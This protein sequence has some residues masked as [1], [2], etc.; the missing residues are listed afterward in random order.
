[1]TRREL[2]LAALTFALAA[3]RQDATAPTVRGTEPDPD[4]GASVS[5]ASNTYAFTTI[6]DSNRDGFDPSTFGC[7]ALNDPGSVA[8]RA[9]RPNG[10]T[11]IYRGRGGPL[12]TIV[13]DG[14][15]IYDFIGR[16]PS[17]NNLGDVSFAA[18]LDAGGEAI[19]RG[20]GGQLTTIAQTQPGPFNFFGFDTS[21]NDQGNVAFKAELDTFDEGLF[22]GSGGAVTTVYLASTSQFSGT[23]T[24]PA[25]NNAG[26]I[27]FEERLDN[28][29]QGMFRW[30][31]G[32]FTTIATDAAALI[33][34]F[35]GVPA[36]SENGLVA[37]HA[38]D[39]LGSDE[40]IGRGS[41]GRPV[42]VVTSRGPFATFDFNGPSV[43]DSARV[44]FT[45]T[46][47]SGV[48]GVFAGTDPV[49]DRVIATGDSLAGSTVTNLI[50]CREALNNRGQVA[51]QAQLAD[52]RTLVVRATP[53]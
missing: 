15:Q 22:F 47:D 19:L 2:T 16:H 20:R 8:V 43:N 37:F 29:R 32:S 51:F 31:P 13:E 53:L 45:A 27:A 26:Q 9:E 34:F 39:D 4:A 46:L 24:G 14:G 40:G 18:S 6:V 49:L 44:A 48:Q 28:G 38:F 5:P 36:L 30:N 11:G 21:V 1:M 50:S 3:C 25:I 7:P 12:T 10:A 41:G 52:G 23:D 42:P 17:I 35:D 33:G